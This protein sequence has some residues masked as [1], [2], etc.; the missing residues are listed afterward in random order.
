M[1]IPSLT[2][3]QTYALELIKKSILINIETPNYS[4]I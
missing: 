1:L 4:A 2:K 3:R